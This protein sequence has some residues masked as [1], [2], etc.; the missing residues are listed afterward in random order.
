[1]P[2]PMPPPQMAGPGMPGMGPSPMGGPPPQLMQALQQMQGAPGLSRVKEALEMASS[3]VG[4][5][6][7]TAY[8]IS[9]KASV[10]L[11]NK[12]IQSAREILE[13]ESAGPSGPPPDLGGGMGSPPMS[14]PP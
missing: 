9:A 10:K 13:H 7:Q 11:A 4:L 14:G 2:L 3:G 8:T 12:E 1:M 6:L 5:A